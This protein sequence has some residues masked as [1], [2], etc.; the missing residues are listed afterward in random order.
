MFLAYVCL[1]WAYKYTNKQT[2]KN[3]N[4]FIVS[5]IALLYT[6]TLGIFWFTI[7][8]CGL[9]LSLLF[10]KKYFVL[11]KILLT[12]LIIFS[13]YLPWLFVMLH[14]YQQFAG[15]FWLE[16]KPEEKLYNLS[17]MFAFN[18]GPLH[19]DLQFYKIIY[20]NLYYLLIT[21]LIFGFLKKG[22]V[23]LISFLITLSLLV[24][25]YIS[26]YKPLF[27]GRYFVF[28]SP[29]TSILG[30]YMAYYLISNLTNKNYQK[31]IKLTLFSIL[32]LFYLFNIYYLWSDYFLGVSRVDYSII[33]NVN[34]DNLYT[35]SDLDIMPCMIYYPNCYYVKNHHEI[36]SYTGILQLQKKP[37]LNSWQNISGANIGIIFRNGEYQNI[38]NIILDQGYSQNDILSLGDNTYL[39]ILTK[40]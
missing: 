9:T 5:S 12:S 2:N 14:Q 11:K 4:L 30:A 7:V 38:E 33:K 25:Y 28:L 13:L 26:Y 18:E 16:F 3:R 35:T 24:L 6:Q 27:Y 15:S 17:A 32:G 19:F 36:K 10:I 34:A 20:K 23:R 39:S 22:F 8:F 21:V 31:T 1:Y 37:I 40:H 29:L